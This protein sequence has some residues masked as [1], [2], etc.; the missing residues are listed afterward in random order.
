MPFSPVSTKAFS[1]VRS[2][3]H[4]STGLRSASSNPVEIIGNFLSSSPTGLNHCSYCCG[5][6]SSTVSSVDCSDNTLVRIRNQRALRRLR[7]EEHTSH[8]R[9]SYAVFCLKKKKKNN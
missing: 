3:S 2:V 8:V 1:S 5:T 9:I 6:S 7:S 4:E